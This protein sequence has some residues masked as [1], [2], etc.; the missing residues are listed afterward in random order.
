VDERTPQAGLEDHR[1]GQS[2][3]LARSGAV[4]E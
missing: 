1:L 2:V 3:G 4:F